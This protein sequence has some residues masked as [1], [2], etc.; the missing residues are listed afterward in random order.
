[1]YFSISRIVNF[2]KLL[3]GKI[4]KC[5]LKQD[6]FVQ[7]ELNALYE[8]PDLNMTDC[9]VTVARVFLLMFFFH[10]LLPIAPL[11]GLIGFILLYWVW[12][13]QLLRVTQ[14]PEDLGLKF[15]LDLINL[16]LYYPLIYCVSE[17]ANLVLI[18]FC[19]PALSV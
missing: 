1:M 19:G 10:V 2:G 6:V 13:Y 18:V 14:L 8:F 7:A 5:F 16:I 15:T 3:L 4:K 11:A 12:K 17:L 9:G